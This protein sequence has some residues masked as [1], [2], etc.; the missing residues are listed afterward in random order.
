MI[1]TDATLEHFFKIHISRPLVGL[2]TSFLAVSKGEIE[3][4]PLDI[5]RTL[6]GCQELSKICANDARCVNQVSI[7]LNNYISASE[8]ANKAK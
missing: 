3:Y 6:S 5:I 1:F 8:Q 7:Y 2:E 4:F